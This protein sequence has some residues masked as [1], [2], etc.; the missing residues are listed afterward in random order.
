MVRRK[1][2]KQI[3]FAT[4]ANEVGFSLRGLSGYIYMMVFHETDQQ[5]L[6]S[7]LSLA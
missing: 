5:N 2:L 1:L 7:G 4:Y 6:I 3:L